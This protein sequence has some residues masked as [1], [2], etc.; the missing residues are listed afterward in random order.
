SADVSVSLSLLQEKRA[1]NDGG[2]GTGGDSSDVVRD[3]LRIFGGSV[4]QVKRP[5]EMKGFL[6]P[7]VS[8]A[9]EI[10]SSRRRRCRRSSPACRKSWRIAPSRARPAAAWC[11]S[12]SRDN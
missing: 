12:P 2:A 5:E 8:A 9:W 3:A 11:A 10:F 6:C 1:Q 4:R 7:R